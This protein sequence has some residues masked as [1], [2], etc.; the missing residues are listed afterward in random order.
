MSA[1][2]IRTILTLAGYIL[3]GLAMY[4]ENKKYD[5]DRSMLKAELKK[6]IMRDLAK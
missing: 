2:T 5:I 1:Y 4:L 6:E 3:A